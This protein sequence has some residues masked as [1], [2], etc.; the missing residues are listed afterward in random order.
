MGLGALK[1]IDSDFGQFVVVM[2]LVFGSGYL[3]AMPLVRELQINDGASFLAQPIA[4]KRLWW[5]KWVSA[6]ACWL[7]LLITFAAVSNAVC[8]SRESWVAFRLNLVWMC[9]AIICAGPL[10]ALLWRQSWP[11]FALACGSPFPVMTS[12]L[13]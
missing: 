7:I 4:R 9:A 13:L 6:C 3:G 10:S 8:D 12:I 11:A 2:A 1:P 5:E